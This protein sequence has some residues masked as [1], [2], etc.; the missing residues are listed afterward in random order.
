MDD[1]YDSMVETYKSFKSLNIKMNHFSKWWDLRGRNPTEY[2]VT[3]RELF[4]MYHKIKT[5]FTYVNPGE[6]KKLLGTDIRKKDLR[7]NHHYELIY[8]WEY[9][10]PR[11]YFRV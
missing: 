3:L 5:D 7:L 4:E 1:R 11:R 9:Q 10:L 6:I 2:G 8:L